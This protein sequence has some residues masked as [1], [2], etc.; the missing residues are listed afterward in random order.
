MPRTGRPGG[1][2]D[3]GGPDEVD[4][5]AAG[6]TLRCKGQGHG[7]RCVH[8]KAGRRCRV[9]SHRHQPGHGHGSRH[10]GDQVSRVDPPRATREV[11]E[12]EMYSRQSN[13]DG[14]RRYPGV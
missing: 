9:R 10:F 3:V 7:C 13:G 1:M 6:G 2:G 4:R 12:P 11:L 14:V 8:D 5:V